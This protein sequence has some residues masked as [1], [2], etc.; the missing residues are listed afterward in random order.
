MHA[1]SCLTL[2]DPMDC[3]PPGSSV[4]GILQARI[5]EWDATPF[6]KGPSQHRDRISHP[7]HW[8]VYP[9]PSSHR[10]RAWGEGWQRMRWLDDIIDSMGKSLSKLQEVVKDREAWCAII[11]GVAKCRTRLSDWITLPP[12]KS[13]QIP[14]KHLSYKN[15]FGDHQFT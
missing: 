11:H 3:S 1:Q 6:S 4:H 9:L 14:Y 15:P 8:Q 10:L 5:L 7:L 12:G 2:H 13:C